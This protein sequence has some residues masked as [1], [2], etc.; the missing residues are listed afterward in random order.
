[1]EQN[2]PVQV[3]RRADEVVGGRCS[4]ATSVRA[5]LGRRVGDEGTLVL[6]ALEAPH[7]KNRPGDTGELVGE[8]DRQH[9]V[10]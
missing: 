7:V 6:N 9:V 3:L 8:R 1:M 4:R 2:Y 10:V 5:V